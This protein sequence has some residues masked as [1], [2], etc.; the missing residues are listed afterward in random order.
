MANTKVPKEM[1]QDGAYMSI[2]ATTAGI[3]GFLKEK[4]IP[5]KEF[6]AYFGDKYED[7]F[8]DLEGEPI[9]DVMQHLLMLEILPMGAQIVSTKATKDRAEA[10]ITSLP[11]KDVLEKF[12]TT[13][14]ELLSGF[15]VT[16]RE[17]E[18]MYDTF[19][20]AMEA[21][22]L[23]FKHAVKEGNEVLTLERAPKK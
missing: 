21:I 20:P 23:K 15:K 8:S 12:G 19:T 3:L 7:S 18:S 1:L 2:A 14:K 9:A 5:I 4:G 6:V 16:A 13:P 10:V 17:F 22:G 11:P